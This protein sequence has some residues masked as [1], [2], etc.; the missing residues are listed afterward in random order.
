MQWECQS[1]CSRCSIHSSEF[2]LMKMGDRGES[3]RQNNIGGSSGTERINGGFYARVLIVPVHIQALNMLFLCVG[4]LKSVAFELNG[5]YPSARSAFRKM[6]SSFRVAY[7][8]C[9]YWIRACKVWKR[10]TMVLM[11]PA[12]VTFI[13]MTFTK[14]LIIS[15]HHRPSDMAL[16]PQP[17]QQQELRLL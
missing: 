4:E 12:E 9:Q 14:Q 7:F 3:R 2:R 13:E 10:S 6:S 1:I 11:H 5:L 15:H 16:N 8:R 17:E